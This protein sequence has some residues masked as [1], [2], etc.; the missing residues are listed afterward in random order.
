MKGFTSA[1]KALAAAAF[2]ATSVIAD[3]DPIVI[4]AGHVQALLLVHYLI[5]YLSQGSK[6]FYKSNGTE[7]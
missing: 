6:F 7:L 5:N 1:S 4:K 2:C 3:L